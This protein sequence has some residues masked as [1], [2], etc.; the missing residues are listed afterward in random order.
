[1]Q[2]LAA[3]GAGPSPENTARRCPNSAEDLYQPALNI[4]LG[5]AFMRD[6][7][8]KFGRIEYVAVAYNAGPDRVPQWRA[9]LAARDGRICRSDPVQGNKRLRPGR[10]PQ[11]RP[12]PPPLRR[13]GNFKSNVGV[14]PLRSEIDSMTPQQLAQT[15]PDVT[16]DTDSSE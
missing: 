13:N 9:T 4:E 11:L 16:L 12:I 1:M 10:H 8:D 15:F 14:R 3:D 6:Q 2:L 7:F 5:T